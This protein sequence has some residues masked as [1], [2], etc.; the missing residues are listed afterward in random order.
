MGFPVA[1]CNLK[2]TNLYLK[3]KC[4]FSVVKFL[5]V[6]FIVAIDIMTLHDLYNIFCCS[7]YFFILSY[8]PYCIGALR[9]MIVDDSIK[10]NVGRKFE[11]IR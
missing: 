11:V 10:K 2:M 4:T 1:N 3:G 6:S 5:L 9:S 8:H 7:F